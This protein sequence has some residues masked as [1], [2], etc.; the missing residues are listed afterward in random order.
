MKLWARIAKATPGWLWT[1]IL[2]WIAANRPVVLALSSFV[3]SA[4][5]GVTV[6]QGK[7]TPSFQAQAVLLG[8]G[9]AIAVLLLAGAVPRDYENADQFDLLLPII[10]RVLKLAPTDRITVHRIHRLPWRGY[11]QLTDYYPL[12]RRHTRGRTF[13]LSHGIVVQ[14]FTTLEPHHWFVPEDKT[15]EQAMSDRWS[16][17]RHEICS[18]TQNRCS[19]LV[20]PSG[21]W[22]DYAHV[23]LYLDSDRRETFD[24]VRGPAAE[25]ALRELFADAFLRILHEPA[26]VP[27]LP[28]APVAAK[29]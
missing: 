12:G 17:T 26:N 24:D 14:A 1:A 11:E 4:L 28:A 23:V 9:L 13:P 20:F 16:F 7:D 3:A 5:M 2:R 8:L 18:L 19:F 15:F 6:A 21:Q 22:G 29:E 27:P 25:A 10:H